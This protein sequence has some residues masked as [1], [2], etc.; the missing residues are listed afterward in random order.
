MGTPT[1]DYLD[2]HRD[3]V[4]AQLSEWVRLPS[5]AGIPAHKIDLQRSANWLAGALRAI[6]VPSVEVWDTDG[7]PAVY[8]EWCAAPGAP[9]VLVYS[10]HDVRTAKDGQWQETPP[11]TTIDDVH[12]GRPA[13]QVRDCLLTAAHWQAAHEGLDG[14][15]IDVRSGTARPAWDVVRDL[16]AVVGP[17]L[18]RHGDTAFVVAH[19]ARLREEGTGAARQRRVY[20]RA[21]DIHAVLNDLAEQT[22]GGRSDA[23]EAARPPA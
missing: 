2:R 8:G 5:V 14:S 1:R 19:L 23:L 22:A 13:L 10:H 17:G 9:T 7:G 6:G 20:R 12:A 3:T 11:S 21:G 15:L 18:Q 4:V 16:L